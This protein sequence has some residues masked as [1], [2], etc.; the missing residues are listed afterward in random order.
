MDEQLLS[1][2]PFFP[3]ERRSGEHVGGD[4]SKEYTQALLRF[5]DELLRTLLSIYVATLIPEL[6][7]REGSTLAHTCN[8]IKKIETWSDR[9]QCDMRGKSTADVFFHTTEGC[10]GCRR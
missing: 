3:P 8:S 6:N 5:T 4:L 1:F 10:V 2:F 7:K 9:Y